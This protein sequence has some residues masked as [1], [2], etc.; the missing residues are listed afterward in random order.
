[1][2]IELLNQHT[3]A[4]K[5]PLLRL[6]NVILLAS[7]EKRAVVL[8]LPNPLVTLIGAEPFKSVIKFADHHHGRRVNTT[9]P[10]L[11]ISAQYQ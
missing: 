10:V 8:Y 4:C 2:Q 3:Y 5:T 6:I 9:F 11:E 7:L 1:M